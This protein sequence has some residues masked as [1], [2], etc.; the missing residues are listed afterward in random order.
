MFKVKVKIKQLNQGVRCQSS[1]SPAYAGLVAK[2][3]MVDSHMATPG[4]RG[5]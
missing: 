2:L 3:Q 5:E 4:Q 1:M